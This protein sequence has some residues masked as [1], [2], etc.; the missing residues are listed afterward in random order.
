MLRRSTLLS[1]CLAQLLRLPRKF[2]GS[3]QLLLRFHMLPEASLT[4]PL[5]LQLSSAHG[6]PFPMG[7]EAVLGAQV[8]WE[9]TPGNRGSPVYK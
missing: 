8:D 5:L 6:Q 7:P 2:Y 9:Q 4:S 1:L 3:L